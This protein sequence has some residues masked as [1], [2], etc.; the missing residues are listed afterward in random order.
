MHTSPASTASS[1]RASVRIVSAVDIMD[2]SCL[3]VCGFP[4]QAMIITCRYSSSVRS[5]GLVFIIESPLPTHHFRTGCPG[6]NPWTWLTDNTEFCG[7]LYGYRGVTST[8][9]AVSTADLCRDF[10][11]VRRGENCVWRH[12]NLTIVA[13]EQCWTSRFHLRSNQKVIASCIV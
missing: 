2:C 5:F 9:T 13:E 10:S 7:H 6:A 1:M 12:I 4:V 8:L 11:L 3:S